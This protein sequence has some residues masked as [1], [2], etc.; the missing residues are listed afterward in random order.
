MPRAHGNE[1]KR[2]RSCNKDKGPAIRFPFWQMVQQPADCCYI[3]SGFGLSCSSSPENKTLLE[4]PLS[5]KVLVQKIDYRQQEIYV[6]KPNKCFPSLNL[7]SSPF[8]FSK[9]FVDSNS[10]FSCPSAPLTSL[11]HQVT[12]LS[13]PGHLVYAISSDDLIEDQPLLSC[14][15]M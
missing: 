9:R 15:K 1:C 6:D 11:G 13:S 4:L 3:W 8:Q 10:L 5:V 12:C 2:Q 14:V 7:S